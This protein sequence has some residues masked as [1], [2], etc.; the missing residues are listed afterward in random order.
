MAKEVKH[1]TCIEDLR[2]SDSVKLKAKDYIRR[3]MVSL[4][5]NHT[6]T[7]VPNLENEASPKTD[8]PHLQ[9]NW[10]MVES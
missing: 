3:Y 8:L 2:V 7:E 4:D 9:P 1:I 5:I 10:G 6:I